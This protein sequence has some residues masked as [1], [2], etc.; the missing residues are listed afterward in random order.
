MPSIEKQP[1]RANLVLVPLL[2]D[3]VDARREAAPDLKLQAGPLARCELLV[4]AG[5]ELKVLVDE[6]QRAASRGGGVVRAEVAS[7]V[8]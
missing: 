7:A 8:G 1:D 6:V 3:V 4:R 5:P 2:V